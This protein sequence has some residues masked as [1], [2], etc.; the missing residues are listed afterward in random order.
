MKHANKAIL[1]TTI[2]AILGG[3]AAA[4]ATSPCGDLGECKVLVEINSS[5]G[6]AGLHFLMDGD[7]FVYGAMYN[8]DWR[9]IYS[10]K[11]RREMRDQIASLLAK[12]GYSSDSAEPSSTT[13]G[14]DES[15]QVEVIE[16]E[17]LDQEDGSVEEPVDIEEIKSDS[18][19]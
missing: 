18:D 13:A 19:S 6:D 5:D 8:P 3:G 7:G 14:V 11:T 12:L 10:Y 2:A 4:N 17:L 1:A 15:E 16:G 9:K